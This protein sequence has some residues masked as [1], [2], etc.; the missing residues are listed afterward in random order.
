VAELGEHEDEEHR[1]EEDEER[2]GREPAVGG[3]CRRPSG[4][5][6]GKH[7]EEEEVELA[8]HEA[9]P[10]ED[11]DRRRGA[12]AA[13]DVG[14]PRHEADDDEH[15]PDGGKGTSVGLVTTTVVHSSGCTGDDHVHE[16]EKL[17]S[18]LAREMGRQ[19]G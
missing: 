4:R 1:E 12:V 16:R 7:D 5:V 2:A 18:R 11:A 6:G 14:P 17:G 9:S 3:L 8:G 19:G 13:E 10:E 15:G